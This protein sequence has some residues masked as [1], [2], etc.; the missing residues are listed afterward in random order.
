MSIRTV[1]LSSAGQPPEV[2]ILFGQAQVGNYRCFLWDTKGENSK[3]IAHGN[4]IDPVP[5]RFPLGVSAKGLD[6]QIFSCESIIQAPS[7]GP[8]QIYSLFILF[9]QDGNVLAD[10]VIQETGP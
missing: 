8:G 1:T 7:P 5:D 2:E 6:K 10:G 3:Q 4:N 9:R